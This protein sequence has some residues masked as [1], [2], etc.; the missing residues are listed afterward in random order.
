M[1]EFLTIWFL[2]GIILDALFVVQ[3]Y[4]MKSGKVGKILQV[5]YKR[6]TRFWGDTPAI[7]IPGIIGLVFWPYMLAGLIYFVRRV[8]Q[9]RARLRE[10]G[11]LLNEQRCYP[12]WQTNQDLKTIGRDYN[13]DPR[14]VKREL[15]R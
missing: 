12:D 10:Y 7:A 3:V 14:T 11:R 5:N 8:L 13:R 9:E 6:E 4:L 1:R 2:A 15:E